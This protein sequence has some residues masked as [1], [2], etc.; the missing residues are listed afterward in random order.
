MSQRLKAHIP[1]KDLLE[2][3]MSQV[4]NV[5][6]PGQESGRLYRRFAAGNHLY[7]CIM[8]LR[9]VP[10]FLLCL[11]SL[12]CAH[13]NHEGL[14]PKEGES[15]QQYAMRHVRPSRSPQWHALLTLM[16]QMIKEHH[17]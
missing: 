17:M 3:G 10:L 16:L 6:P 9:A 8:T 1:R 12:V 14:G 13:G 15:I 5:A 7:R 4:N 2:A 11:F